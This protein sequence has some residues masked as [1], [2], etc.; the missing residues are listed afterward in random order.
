MALLIC[1]S[2]RKSTGKALSL[3]QSL[4]PL[5]VI[6][7]S[8]LSSHMLHLEAKTSNDLRQMWCAAGGGGSLAAMS[9]L[10]L[11][12]HSFLKE[13]RL[14]SLPEVLCPLQ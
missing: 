1:M 7:S 5:S 6:L 12:A 11:L 9:L 8:E 3:W 14:S 4:A 10:Q 2:H 13:C